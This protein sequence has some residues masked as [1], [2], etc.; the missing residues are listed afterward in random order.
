M[1][2]LD[3]NEFTSTELVA[4]A[5]TPAFRDA[6]RYV[7]ID[8]AAAYRAAMTPALRPNAQLVVDH[9]YLVKSATDV[10]TQVRRRVTWDLR[11]RPG[12]K[13]MMRTVVMSSTGS[14]DQPVPCLP[15]HPS[16]RPRVRDACDD[17]E[18]TSR[19]QAHDAEVPRPRRQVF[20]RHQR[21]RRAR[22][23]TR[24]V[25][26]TAPSAGP[27]RAPQPSLPRWPDGEAVPHV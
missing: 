10:V 9:S 1:P 15:G 12:R 5:R 21:H 8:P 23:H 11:N 13:V 24:A 16:P 2:E 18:P 4:A 19:T 26:G 14:L 17:V 27:A 20:A 6:V 3:S 7:V 25:V 22:E